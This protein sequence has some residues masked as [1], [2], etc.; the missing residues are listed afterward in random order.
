MS[1]QPATIPSNEAISTGLHPNGVSPSVQ[2]L[3]QYLDSSAANLTHNFAARDLNRILSSELNQSQIN[4]FPKPMDP[5]LQATIDLLDGRTTP[6]DVWYSASNLLKQKL[7]DYLAVLGCNMPNELLQFTKSKIQTEAFNQGKNESVADDWDEYAKR[8]SRRATSPSYFPTGIPSLDQALGGGIHGQTIVLGDKGVG[9]TWL[10]VNCSLE[11]LKSESTAVLFYSLDVPKARIM[12]RILCR[13][14]GMEHREISN[15]VNEQLT[16]RIQHAI[17]REK[18]ARMRIV[19]RDFTEQLIHGMDEQIRLGMTHFSIEQDV[20]RL[21]KSTKARRILVIIDLFQ[22][23]VTPSSMTSSEYDHH[24]LD[25]IDRASQTLRRYFG[26]GNVAFLVTS[27]MR[28]REGSRANQLPTMD[29]IKGDGRIPSDADNVLI[30]STD[31]RIDDDINKV[32][33]QIAKGRDGVIRG[34]HELDFNHR[35]GFFGIQ[36][37]APKE[38]LPAAVCSSPTN[39]FEE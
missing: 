11:A 28:K 25:S 32:V 36:A 29:D 35:K 37:V 6:D 27:E 19:E 10:L 30:L 7:D 12:D 38:A 9:K 14:L 24:R 4:I 26:D 1:N 16:A 33:L 13:E 22:K 20:F 31:R 3:Q 5:V 21:S 18:L 15:G 23:M 34:N 2:R 39:P 8:L 17:P